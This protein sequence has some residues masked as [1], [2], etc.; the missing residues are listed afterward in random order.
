MIFKRRLKAVQVSNLAEID[1]MVASG[2]PVLIDFFQFGCA[3]CKVMDGIVDEIADEFGPSA[4]V[5]KA[6]VAKMPGAVQKYKVRAT[7]TF[8]LVSTTARQKKQGKP[9]GAQAVA[10]QRWRA[11]GLVKKDQLRRVLEREGAQPLEA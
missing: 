2:K 3:P 9:G 11:S 7:P 10:T 6:N 1:D 4:H 5:V 8:V